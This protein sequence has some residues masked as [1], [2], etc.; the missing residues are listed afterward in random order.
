M[1]MSKTQEEIRKL[2]TE[3]IGDGGKP[4]LW[5]ITQS[6]Y[7]KAQDYYEHYSM[8][9][10]LLP[11]YNDYDSYT[12]V[13]ESYEEAVEAFEDIE[14]DPVLGVGTV[15]MEDREIGVVREKWLVKKVIVCYEE[16]EQDD[17]DYYNK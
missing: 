15:Y 13:F 7:C 10:E 2:A 17:S 5:F 1:E 6:P 9:D 16:D 11:G 3:V 14:L 8:Y 12:E 4:N